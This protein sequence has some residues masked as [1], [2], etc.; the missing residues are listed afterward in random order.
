MPVS[1]RPRFAASD[2]VARIKDN[3]GRIHRMGDGASVFVLTGNKELADWLLRIGGKRYHAPGL[4]DQDG[5]LRARD[6]V[7]E[8][9][10]YI[11]TIPVKDDP[12]IGASRAIWA[13][14]A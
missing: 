10:I 12:D 3:G 1:P 7:R 5:Y 13:A 6:G 4:G 11:H 9:D 8:W 2:L 14:A